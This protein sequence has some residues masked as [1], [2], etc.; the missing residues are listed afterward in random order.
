[1]PS[2]D[3]PATESSFTERLESGW[4]LATDHLPLA[5]VPLVSSLTSVGD[6]ERALAAPGWH[7]GIALGLPV[8]PPDLWSF[9]SLP[10]REPGLHVSPTLPVLPLL[11]AM[12]AALVAGLLGSVHQLLSTGSYDFARNV[13]RYF[14]RVLG[15]ELLVWA[16]GLAAVGIGAIAL[17]LAVLAIPG[18]FVLAYLF[19]AAPYL[20]VV[21]DL[22]VAD[23][24]AR[25][26]GWASTGGP[27][28]SYA[29]GY[30]VFTAIVSVVA[31]VVA[32]N[33]G[34]FGVLVGA[35]AT[36]PVA[37]ALTVATTGFVADMAAAERERGGAGSDG[38]EERRGGC[39]RTDRRDDRD[40]GRDGAP[41]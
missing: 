23:A 13:R 11:V 30:A 32:V 35:L 21:E 1:M 16:V 41:R 29:V 25:S 10:S 5:V 15:Y 37:L 38:G 3:A 27:Y 12:Q 2:T 8:A 26:Y 22:G 36:A 33:A 9:V 4:E 17:P 31:T 18:Y 7:A 19:Y 40:D 20:L 6:V 39:G 24:L 34:P 28:L 14:V